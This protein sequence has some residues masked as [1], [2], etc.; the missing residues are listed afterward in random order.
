MRPGMGFSYPAGHSVWLEFVNIVFIIFIFTASFLQ[1]PSY[2]MHV[3]VIFSVDRV[4]MW[5]NYFK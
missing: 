4:K 3:I 1:L 2:Q 5:F